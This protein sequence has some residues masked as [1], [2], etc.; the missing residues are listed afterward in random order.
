MLMHLKSPKRKQTCLS[1]HASRIVKIA[2]SFAIVALSNRLCRLAA[3]ATLYY[4]DAPKTAECGGRQTSISI[5]G[6]KLRAMRS[7]WRS[8]KN[9]L[10]YGRAQSTT[11]NVLVNY[12]SGE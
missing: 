6:N 1:R 2:T 5:F 11:T 4:I 10:I 8:N 9:R 12:F 7:G 3:P